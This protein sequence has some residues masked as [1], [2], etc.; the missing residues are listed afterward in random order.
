MQSLDRVGDVA[1]APGLGSVAVDLDRLADKRPLDHPRDH[2]PILAAL[3]GA[4]GVEK[5]DDHA[6][7]PALLV[8]RQRK[9]LV[10]RLRVGIGP[11]AGSCR[12]VDPARVLGERLLLAVVAVDLGRRCDQHPFAETGAVLEHVLRAL[13]I[14]EERVPRL[15][16]DQPDTHCCGEVVDDVA[17]VDELADD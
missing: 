3:P 9:E 7:E 14:G 12:P 15:L 8:Q 13:D 1:E 2:H 16:D 5:T 6:V 17:L 10:H 4:D 11:A